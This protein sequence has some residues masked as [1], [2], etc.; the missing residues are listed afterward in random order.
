MDKTATIRLE[1]KGYGS[2]D[3]HL[4]AGL[5]A[6]LTRDSHGWKFWV[7]NIWGDRVSGDGL[8]GQRVPAHFAEFLTDQIGDS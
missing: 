8:K 1:P 4:G 5:I 2:Y 7:L 6:E 3:L